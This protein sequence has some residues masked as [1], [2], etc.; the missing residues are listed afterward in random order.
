[1]LAAMNTPA[2]LPPTLPDTWATRLNRWLLPAWCKGVLWLLCALPALHWGWL[3]R[4]GALEVAALVRDS[5]LWATHLL[6]ATLSI[7][8]LRHGAGLHSL[9]RWRRSLG[10]AAF[11][12]ALLHLLAYAGLDRF[13]LWSEIRH[14]FATSPMPALGLAAGVLMLPLALTAS[15]WAV[16]W[17]Q[18]PLWNK[19]H[20][21]VYAVALLAVL[22]EVWASWAAQRY[23]WMLLHAAWLAAVLG[24]R[25]HAKAHTPPPPATGLWQ[26]QGVADN[27]CSSSDSGQSRNGG[28]GCH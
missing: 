14:D 4:Q 16:R 11:A 9:L 2:S 8:P 3:H 19:L 27:W 6:L 24:W 13:W 20:Q 23:G 25:L 17:L 15:N 26:G 12:Y 22:H 5:G 18:G 10:L 28:C 1:M 21:L 7:T